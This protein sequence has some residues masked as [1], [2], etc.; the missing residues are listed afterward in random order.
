[1]AANLVRMAA[2]FA[3]QTVK[4]AVTSFSY[5][6]NIFWNIQEKKRLAV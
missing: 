1:M 2:N 4:C 6:K 5:A 3:R